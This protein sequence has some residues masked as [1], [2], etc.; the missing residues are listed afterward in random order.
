M[1]PALVHEFADACHYIQ[2]YIYITAIMSGV[3]PE[4]VRPD[5][6]EVKRAEE[7]AQKPPAALPEHCLPTEEYLALKVL[8]YL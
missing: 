1:K 4:Y 8:P 5:E 2:N 6:A 3:D 7:L